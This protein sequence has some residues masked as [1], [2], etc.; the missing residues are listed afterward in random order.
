MQV[1]EECTKQ[2]SCGGWSLT[3][4]GLWSSYVSETTENLV[5]VLKVGF[6]FGLFEQ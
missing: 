3:I 2:S 1:D 5:E 6:A 4:L